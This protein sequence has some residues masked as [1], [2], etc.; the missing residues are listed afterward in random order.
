MNAAYTNGCDGQG[1]PGPCTG[2]TQSECPGA[3]VG[4]GTMDGTV[5]QC[6]ANNIGVSC[7]CK[8]LTAQADRVRSSSP[9]VRGRRRTE[10]GE[11]GKGKE[12]ASE[13]KNAKKVRWFGKQSYVNDGDARVPSDL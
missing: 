7:R 12:E 4:T 5:Y 9:S 10:A 2:P 6:Q 3:F 11:G 8:K 13:A 1:P